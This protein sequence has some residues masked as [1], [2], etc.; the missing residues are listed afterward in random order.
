M[1]LDR[2]QQV[3]VKRRSSPQTSQ[4]INNDFSCIFICASKW[5]QYWDWP[6]EKSANWMVLQPRDSGPIAPE[7]LS[8]PAMNLREP[9][10]YGHF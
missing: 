1:R 6:A 2:D 10:I 3:N 7:D 8:S 5:Q 4:V 9:R